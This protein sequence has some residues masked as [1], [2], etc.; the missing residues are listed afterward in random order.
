MKREDE[1]DWTLDTSSVPE[2]EWRN[3]QV[4]AFNL[5]NLSELVRQ[6]Q[7]ALDL[8]DHARSQKNFGLPDVAATHWATMAG[9][10]AAFT[11]YH[12]RA[13]LE[14]V[15]ARVGACRSIIGQVDTKALEVARQTL[16]EQFPH[17]KN[18][19]D[20]IGHSADRIFKPDDID[21]H[22]FSKEKGGIIVGQI[23][24]GDFIISHKNDVLSL[25]MDDQTRER[26]R[27][28]KLAVYE[29]LGR[30]LSRPQKERDSDRS[31]PAPADQTTQ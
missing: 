29:A 15:V 7:F 17:A 30:L 28:L 24:Q 21:A 14:A 11:V 20:A 19:R 9:M 13:S 4:L 26:L 22:A 16:R 5:H 2:G 31:A 3:V 25:P 18:I 10:H 1:D 27:A 23:F 8:L 6:F 12:F